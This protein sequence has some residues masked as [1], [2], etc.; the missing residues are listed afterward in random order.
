MN[1]TKIDEATVTSSDGVRIKYSRESL[2]YI[3]PERR[4][5][6]PIEHLAQPYEMLIQLPPAPRWMVE[7]READMLTA[8]ETNAVRHRI[9]T[10]LTF[11]G[12]KYRFS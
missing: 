12:R 11:L 10:A 2:T 3:E 7:A 8:S 4:L 9:S 5:T 6:V 1:L